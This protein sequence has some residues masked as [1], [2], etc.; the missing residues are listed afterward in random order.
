MK[1][2]RGVLAELDFKY[3]APIQPI[4]LPKGNQY[5]DVG[6]LQARH[7]QFAGFPS[8][9]AAGTFLGAELARAPS[10]TMR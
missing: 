10:Q 2:L 8:D 6:S 3:T 7:S 4:L 9:Y 1:W 5:Q